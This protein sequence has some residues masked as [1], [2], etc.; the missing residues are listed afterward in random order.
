[1]LISL[2]LYQR[3]GSAET[4]VVDE[5]LEATQVMSKVI[6]STT[7]KF[8]RRYIAATSTRTEIRIQRG[9]GGL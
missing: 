6:S 5:V 9:Y 3:V 2:K 8:I 1:M 4:V 7:Q